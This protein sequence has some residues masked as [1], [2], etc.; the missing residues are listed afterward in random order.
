MTATVKLKLVGADRYACTLLGEEVMERGESRYVTEEA[1]ETLMKET[2][3]DALN[4]VHEIFKD[5]TGTPDTPADDEE[6]EKPASKSA[7]VS[8][9]AKK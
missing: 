7:R 8:R 3:T 9:T 1:A 2:M 6:E 4:N 5:V